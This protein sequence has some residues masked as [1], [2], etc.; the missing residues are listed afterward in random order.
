MANFLE[1]SAEWL[2]DTAK[3]SSGVSVKYRRGA[4]SVTLTAVVGTMDFSVDSD[5]VLIVITSRD[6]IVKLA[7][8]AIGGVATRPQIGD[9]IHETVGG[10]T[11]VYEVLPLNG[12]AQW[13]YSDAFHKRIRIHTKKVREY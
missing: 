10:K 2:A 13:R 3:A 11:H 7:D 1:S 12:Q 8:L 9:E 5:G 4:Q 6:Y